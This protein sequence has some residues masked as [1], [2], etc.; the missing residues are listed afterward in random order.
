MI[1][2]CEGAPDP[3]C[4]GA[5]LCALEHWTRVKLASGGSP[6]LAV[7][8]YDLLEDTL[9][10]FTAKKLLANLLWLHKRDILHIEAELVRDELFLAYLNNK[11]IESSLARWTANH[12]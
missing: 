6:V 8:I 2:I 3:R 5:I 9:L 10:L 1:G 11:N 7:S 4:A 12:K